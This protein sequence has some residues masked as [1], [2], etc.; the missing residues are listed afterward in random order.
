[1]KLAIH[2]KY[3]EKTGIQSYS[4]RLMNFTY[5]HTYAHSPVGC[6]FIYI[7]IYIFFFF[8]LPWVFVAT[9]RLFLVARSRGSSLFPCSGFPPSWPPTLRSTSSRLRASV[10]VLHRLSC[11]ETCGIFPNQ[12]SNQHPLHWHADS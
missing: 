2:R 9:C 12:G 3:S 8:W 6:A 1:M 10:V 7:Y 5:T 4:R 11:P